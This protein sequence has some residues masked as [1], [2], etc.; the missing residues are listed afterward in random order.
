M[1]KKEKEYVEFEV[2][3]KP[4][5]GFKSMFAPDAY[6]TVE[7]IDRFRADKGRCIETAN[8][9]RNLGVKVTHIGEFSMSASCPADR[10]A[11]LFGTKLSKIKPSTEARQPKENRMLAP[12]KVA[13]W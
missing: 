7:T 10:F 13:P 12:A 4:A 6:P 5:E 2:V 9:L 8:K 11:S 3:A 1:A